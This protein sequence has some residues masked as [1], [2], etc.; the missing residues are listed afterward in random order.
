MGSVTHHSDLSGLWDQA[1]R[2]PHLPTHVSG[3]HVLHHGLSA[4]R[5]HCAASLQDGAV[6]GTQPGACCGRLSCTSASA[7]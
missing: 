1:C 2:C 3:P 4:A 6:P 7:D 5:G